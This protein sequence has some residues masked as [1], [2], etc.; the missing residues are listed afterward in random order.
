MEEDRGRV[1]WISEV[2][3]FQDGRLLNIPGEEMNGF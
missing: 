2:N 1:I 3:I